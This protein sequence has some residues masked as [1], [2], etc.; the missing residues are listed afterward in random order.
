[1][2]KSDSLKHHPI[3][4]CTV[5]ARFYRGERGGQRAG[6]MKRQNDIDCLNE[7]CR[8]PDILD[9]RQNLKCIAA[10]T[11]FSEPLTFTVNAS[12][13]RLSSASSKSNK[14]VLL[15]LSIPSPLFA[16]WGLTGTLV[17]SVKSVSVQRVFARKRF[18][19][20]HCRKHHGMCNCSELNGGIPRSFLP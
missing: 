3:L 1:M 18:D 7:I 10:T 9:S 15:I 19:L 20:K 16:K 6:K 5:P 14:S 2:M 12:T 8:Q 4:Y 11:D 13:P 17:R